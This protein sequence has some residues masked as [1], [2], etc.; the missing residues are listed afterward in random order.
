MNQDNISDVETWSIYCF[1]FFLF[2]ADN[3][4]RKNCGRWVFTA[5][6][7][8]Y[9]LWSVVR[10]LELRDICVFVLFSNSAAQQ[11]G[12]SF[13]IFFFF[14]NAVTGPDCNLANLPLLS[15]LI[16]LLPSYA[17]GICTQCGF[18]CWN[19]L[20]L[21]WKGTWEHMFLSK[22]CLLFSLDGALLDV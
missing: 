11:F 12:A 15:P 7:V 13:A 17:A 9:H 20:D 21:S 14:Q 22:L 6:A 8:T 5:T 19:Q 3:S 1:L 18:S 16:F 10:V 4:P 2:D